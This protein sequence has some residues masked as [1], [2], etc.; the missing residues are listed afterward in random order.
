MSERSRLELNRYPFWALRFWH[1]MRLGDWLRLAARHR[2][3]IHPL[4]IPMAVILTGVAGVNSVLYRLQQ[5]RYG[6]ALQE[7]AIDEPPLFILGH[8]RSGTTLLHELL[9]LDPRFAY[10]T[11]YECFAANH[12]L[13]TGKVL[14]RIFWFLLPRRR[15]QD[16]MAVSFNHPQEDEFALVSMGAPSPMLR[17]A[18]P[19]DPPPYLEFLDMEQ[20]DS[21]DLRQWKAKLLDFVRAETFAKRKPLVLKSPPHTG[22]IAVLSELF[23]GARFVHIVRDPRSLFPSSRRLWVALDEA[24]GFQ[25]PHHRQLDDFVFDAFERMYRGFERQRSRVPPGHLCETR[26][27]DLVADP[28]AEM[29]RVY[30]QLGLD[31]F[32]AVREKIADYIAARSDYQVNRHELEPETAELLHQRWGEYMRRYGYVDTAS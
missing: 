30:A 14:P 28:V 11:T 4:R 8:W 16:N 13:L 19:N 12:F 32:E 31:G 27:E 22:R 15:P 23:P 20:V 7:V 26:Y 24:Q 29:E 3:R 18:F 10:P 17:S 9:V 21:E 1:G 25:L 2:F 6:R 5:W